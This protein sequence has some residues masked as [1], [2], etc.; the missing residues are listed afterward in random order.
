MS[1]ESCGIHKTS[2]GG[3]ALIEGVMM[4]GPHQTIMAVRAPDG[5]IVT[6]AMETKS[7]KEKA[8]I[9]GWPIIRGVVNFIESMLFGYKCLM[10]SAELAGMDLEDEELTPFEKKLT[11]KFGDKLMQVVSVIGMV[12]GVILAVGLFMVLPMMAVWGLKFIWADVEAF[13]AVIEGLIKIAIFVL[14][15]ALVSRMKE[16]Q[17][18]FEYHGAEHKSI[19]CYEA[20]LPLEVENIRKCS[21][22][23]PRCGTS[24]II[25]VLIL[26]ILVFS[27][28]NFWGWLRVPIKLLLLPVVVGI[29]YEFIKLAG[30]YDN[31]F[32]RI[33]SAP[34]LWLQRLT[35]REPDDSQ[36]EVAVASL[37]PVIPESKDEDRW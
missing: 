2:I 3:Q 30:R 19:A 15:L 7:V 20:G 8:K 22:F 32:T 17:R 13:G 24:F 9:L 6:E 1:K 27:C 14:Y 18:V 33:L 29:G 37:V 28:I 16:I 25:I 34:G 35:T 11:E 21:R 26:S 12:L 5:Q 31:V 10:K 23:H 4:R 36:I